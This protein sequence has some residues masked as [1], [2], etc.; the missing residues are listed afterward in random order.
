VLKI[1]GEVVIIGD[2]HGQFMDMMGM[3]KKLHRQ[4]G[5]KST[6]YLFLGDYVDRGEFGIEV[7]AYLLAL[8]LK[9]PNDVI[10]LRGNHESLE[11]TSSFNFRHQVLDQFDAEVY[12]EFIQLF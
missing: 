12:D 8:K 5:Q 10:M 7:M 3:F 9:H 11:M 4:P 1:E 6:K 2:I